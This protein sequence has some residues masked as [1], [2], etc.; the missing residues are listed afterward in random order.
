MTIKEKIVE[1]WNKIDAKLKI[2]HFKFHY[3]AYGAILFVL[4]LTVILAQN[5]TNTSTRAQSTS[6]NVLSEDNVIIPES[7]LEDE[8]DINGNNDEEIQTPPADPASASQ[9]ASLDNGNDQ[10]F[11]D[12]PG[13]SL[14]TTSKPN[15]VLI[16]TDDMG[17]IDDR[18]WNRLP[19]IKDLFIDHGARFTNY[20]GETP[21]CCPGRAGLLTGQHTVNHKVVTNSPILFDPSE[22]IATELRKEG[23]YTFIAGKYLNHA[24][25]LKDKTPPGW[26]NVSITP[27]GY[28]NYWIINNGKKLF[29]GDSPDNYSGRVTLNKALVYLKKAPK[30]KPVFAYI[31]PFAT[32]GTKNTNLHPAPDPKFIGSPKCSSLPLLDLP[33]YNEDDMSDKPLFLRSQPKLEAKNGYNLT[34]ECE[35]LLSVEE[36]V[37]KVKER[38]ISQ[39]RLKNTVF[40]LTDDNG[41][42]WGSHRQTGKTFPFTTQLPMFIHWPSGIS[43]NPFTVSDT[44][45]NI[46]IA[47]TLCE[48]AGCQMGPYPNGQ[49]KPDGKSFLSLLKRQTATMGRDAVLE[50]FPNKRDSGGTPQWFAVRTTS[51]N[52]LGLWHYVEYPTTGERELY[53]LSNG[54]CYAWNDSKG[55]DPCE[56]NNLLAPNITPSDYNLKIVSVLKA[57]LKQLRLEKGYKPVPFPT[58]IPTSTPT[59]TPTLSPSPSPTPSVSPSPSPSPTP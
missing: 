54:P 8:Q 48:I 25:T 53:D 44:V 9:L 11:I 14:A 59:P 37:K 52:P 22:T 38:L 30:D 58:A 20:Y 46:D 41:M 28:F 55:G 5:Q 27:G 12:T 40:I 10:T 45:M 16:L 34:K 18:L 56:L 31:A 47:P 6:T 15:I 32:H 3:I 1:K 24:G 19:T 13:D 50:S 42:G 57:R 33:N 43:N 29:E 36:M 17:Y 49:T 26:D 2:R 7:S 21:L 23:Y 4:P 51:E 35:A 39:G